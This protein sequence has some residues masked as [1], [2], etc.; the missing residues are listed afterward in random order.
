MMQL[1]LVSQELWYLNHEWINMNNHHKDGGGVIMLFR[2]YLSGYSHQLGYWLRLHIKKADQHGSRP[3]RNELCAAHASRF[4]P[5]Q[6]KGKGRVI[7]EDHKK[8]T[9]W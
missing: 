3:L 5:A 9:L 8:K 2:S 1:I 6:H 4:Q 7:H